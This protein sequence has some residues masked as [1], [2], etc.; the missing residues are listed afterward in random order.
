MPCSERINF[1]RDSMSTWRADANGV[2]AKTTAERGKCW[3]HWCSMW[4]SSNINPFLNP[5]RV[6]PLERDITTCVFTA[7]VKT[8]YFGRKAQ[9]RAG[10]ISDA[11]ATVSKTIKLAGEP[12][13]IYWYENKYQLSIEH[14]VEGFWRLDP[15]SIP[16]LAVPVA[17]A[18]RAYSDGL[19]YKDPFTKHVGFLRVVA[20]YFL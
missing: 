8:W 12:N 18:K 14:M 1:T 7:R 15:N 20:F 5:G 6:P 19:V 3:L 4:P 9:V 10:I 11:L 16:Q 17:V 13:P 2:T